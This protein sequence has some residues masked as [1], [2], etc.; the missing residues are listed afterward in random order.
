MA[1]FTLAM[2]IVQ[3]SLAR[4]LGEADAVRVNAAGIVRDVVSALRGDGEAFNAR[5]DE[6]LLGANDGSPGKTPERHC[7][8]CGHCHAY[9]PDLRGAPYAFETEAEDLAHRRNLKRQQNQRLLDRKAE[10]GGIVRTK[11]KSSPRKERV[12]TTAEI[13]AR[14][15]KQDRTEYFRAYRQRKAQGTGEG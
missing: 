11:R 4:Q 2:R 13:R 14:D 8:A 5:L 7:E 10:A 12:L 6:I 9:S 3:A 15:K 1:E